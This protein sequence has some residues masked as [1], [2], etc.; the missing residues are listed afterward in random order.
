M[1]IL[2][3][4]LKSYKADL[5]SKM[6][7]YAFAFHLISLFKSWTSLDSR[8]GLTSFLGR[9]RPCSSTAWLVARPWADLA[10]PAE[11]SKS[12]LLIALRWVL[13]LNSSMMASEI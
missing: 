10:K 1:I 11:P 5:M 13:R 3:Y 7:T 12:L 8:H 4:G 9:I 6:L 2:M